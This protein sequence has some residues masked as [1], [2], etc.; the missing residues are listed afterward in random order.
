MINLTFEII[1]RKQHSATNQEK[2]IVAECL[3]IFISCISFNSDLL[4]RVY[5]D[6]N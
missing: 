5:S 3:N 2:A 1:L 6:P 4:Q